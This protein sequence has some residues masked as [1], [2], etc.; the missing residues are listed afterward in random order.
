MAEDKSSA[1]V[2]ADWGSIFDKLE[3]AEAGRLIKHF[4]NYIRDKNPEAPDR[5][6]DIAFEP[7]KLQLKRD[8]V[9]WGKTVEKKSESGVLGNL[10]RWNNDLYKKVIKGKIT[11]EN[12]VSL[13]KD[14][15]VSHTDD[16]RQKESHPIANVAVTDNVTVTD[17]KEVHVHALQKYVSENLKNVSRLRDQL[18]KEECEKLIARFNKAVIQKVLIAMENKK[19][20]TKK[21]VSVYLTLLNW[22]E[23]ENGSTGEN[24]A[25]PANETLAERSKRLSAENH[26]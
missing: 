5:L 24:K 2:Y 23:R 9:K 10:K 19:D 17:I 25:A 18:T 3:D 15:K 20:L 7:I 11:L 4:F 22:C 13:A 21:Y 26:P 8:L 1:V 14:R 12:A 16:L 6:T